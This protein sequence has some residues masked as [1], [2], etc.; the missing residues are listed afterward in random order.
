MLNP[1]NPSIPSTPCENGSVEERAREVKVGGRRST[2]IQKGFQSWTRV[3]F[4]AQVL[5][6]VER[7]VE[8]ESRGYNDFTMRGPIVKPL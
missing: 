4:G 5:Q 2:L 6:Q 3:S 7:V 1:S 8:R